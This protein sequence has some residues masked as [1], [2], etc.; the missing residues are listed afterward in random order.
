MDILC[1]VHIF[2]E[3]HK[4]LLN[5]PLTFDCMYTSHSAYAATETE[6]N[7]AKIDGLLPPNLL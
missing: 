5:L 7:G 4:I 2:W 6:S 1:K 3:G